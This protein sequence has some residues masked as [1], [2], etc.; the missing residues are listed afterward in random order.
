M[1]TIEDYLLSQLDQPVVLK[2]GS[3]AVKADG[4]DS[5]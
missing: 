3:T 4:T 2:D 5:I 1:Q